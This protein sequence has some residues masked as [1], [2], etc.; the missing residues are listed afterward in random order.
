MSG[1]AVVTAASRTVLGAHTDR[2]GPELAGLAAQALAAAPVD[3]VFVGLPDGARPAEA[4]YAALAA[5]VGAR[6]PVTGLVDGADAGHAALHAAAAA[7]MS[8]YVDEALVLAFSDRPRVAASAPPADVAWRFAFPGLVAMADTLA[9]RHGLDR[10]ALVDWVLAARG[11]AVPGGVPDPGGTAVDS[12]PPE[13]TAEELAEVGA[14]P[15]ARLHGPGLVA[16]PVRGAAAV[17]V[18]AGGAGARIIS[19]GVVGVDPASA[20]TAALAAAE[21]A[22]HRL[23]LDTDALDAVASGAVFAAEG[24]ALVRAL[25]VPPGRV[26]PRGGGFAAGDPGAARSLCDLVALTEALAASGGRYGL[27]ASGG[28]DS[29]GLGR[30]TL[31]DT[32]RF[33]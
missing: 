12:D 19:L 1:E 20:P 28:A 29:V 25:G 6:V 9:E 15:G 22:L 5:G 4:R 10:D 24:A 16:A 32:A 11:R 17:R 2:T 27:V 23:Q 18:S 8:G 30:A 14:F 33:A 3:A 26:D 7:V 21:Q 31:L 13:G